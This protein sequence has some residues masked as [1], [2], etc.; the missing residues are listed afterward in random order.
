MSAIK[1]GTDG[2]RA[3]MGEDFS[4]K[5]VRLFAQGYSNY[6]KQRWKARDISVIVNYDTRFLSEEFAV[7]AAKIFSL[8]GIKAIMPMRDSPLGAIS[9][10][11]PRHKC[12]GGVNFTASFHKPVYNGIKVFTHKG[13]PAL[14]EETQ[15]IEK[16]IDKVEQD[17]HF[18]PQYPDSELIH[19]IDVKSSYIEYL[20]ELVDFRLIKESGIKV[21]VDNLYGTSRDYLDYILNEH[22]IDMISIHNFPYSSFGGVISSWVS[23]NLKDLSKLVVQQRADIG[24]A[25]DIDG[26]RFGIVDYKGRY[27]PSNIIMPPLIEYLIKVREMEGGIVKSITTTSNIRKVAEYY[28]R[29]VYTTPVGFKYLADVMNSRRVFLA[30]ESSNG[31]SLNGKVKIKD[32]IL[33]SL[34]ITEML[35]YNKLEME[36]ILKDF[37]LRF[38]RL[39]SRDISIPR[40]EGTATLYQKLLKRGKFDFSSYNLG[41]KR[42][43]YT[44]GIKFVF[45]DS[46][47]LIRESGTKAV[48]RIYAESSG[49]KRTQ[50]LIK[51]GRTLIE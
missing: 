42:I 1:F 19:T 12:C 26:D 11:I 39:Y 4:F 41:L 27:L 37:Y 3:K 29:K 5:N 23:D 47:L 9:L 40:K 8:N 21:V 35:A 6:L 25:T 36:K 20:E 2:W 51:M 45:D 43:D 16:E 49:L 50:K 34:L 31:A 24:L 44:D 30:V 28:L 15:R 7:E 14:P 13:I 22:D 32:G 38:P 17:F 48:T 10:Y 18:K 33:F 46:W